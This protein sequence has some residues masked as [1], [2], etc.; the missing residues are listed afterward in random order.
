MDPLIILLV[1]M[2]AMMFFMTRGTRKRQKEMMSFRDSMAPGQRVM[3]ASGYVGTIVEI[4]D[5]LV[6]LESEPGSR[7]QWVKAA[8]SKPYDSVSTAMDTE[9]QSETDG[10]EQ[11][12]FVVP[13]DVSGL[14]TKPGEDTTRRD[15][16][17]K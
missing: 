9:T 17:T 7:T 15:E 6:T 4:G 12:G 10:Q 1:V 16:D 2:V 3:T 5:D 14:I 13:D 11:T 8:I